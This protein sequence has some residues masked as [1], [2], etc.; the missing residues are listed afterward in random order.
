MPVIVTNIPFSVFYVKN[1]VAA[2]IVRVLIYADVVG[3]PCV[4]SQIKVKG[5]LVRKFKFNP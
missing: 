2:K 1:K 3:N 5:M 4:D